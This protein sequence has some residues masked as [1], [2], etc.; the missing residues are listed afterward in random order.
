MSENYCLSCGG[1][2]HQ[3]K[4]C[5]NRITT[6]HFHDGKRFNESPRTRLVCDYIRAD[7]EK[8]I[9]RLSD[10]GFGLHRHLITDPQNCDACRLEKI[11]RYTPIGEVSK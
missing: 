1:H 2:S 3:S 6:D 7:R 11:I 10:T 4:N 5:P 9:E 8:I